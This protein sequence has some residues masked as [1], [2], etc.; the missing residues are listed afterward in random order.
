MI[1]IIVV[2][3]LKRALQENFDKRDKKSADNLPA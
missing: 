2:A 3:S 1:P